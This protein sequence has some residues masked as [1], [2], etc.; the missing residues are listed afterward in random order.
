MEYDQYLSLPFPYLCIDADLNV[1][2]ASANL[3]KCP[4]NVNDFIAVDSIEDFLQFIGAPEMESKVF[5]LNLREE[6]PAPYRIYKKKE[7]CKCHL[8]C[9]PLESL[10]NK[11][12]EQMK[13]MR[14]KLRQSKLRLQELE[15]IKEKYDELDLHRSYLSNVGQLAAGIAHEIRNPLTTIKGFIQLMKPYLIELDK[16]QYA[17]IA[18]DE[19]ERANKLLYQFLNAAKPQ[20]NERKEVVINDLIEDIALLYE[21]EAHLRNIVLETSLQSDIPSIF[22]EEHQLKQVL[23]NMIKN[24]VEAIHSSERNEGKIRLSSER[25]DDDIIISIEDNGCG[26][27][28]DSLNRLF[29][30]FY[31][32]KLSGTGL[33]LAICKQ[34]IS[35]HGG[36]IEISSFLNEGTIFRIR[37]PL[38]PKLQ[39]HA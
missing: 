34:I 31:S 14:H 21:G 4:E 29:T 35:E 36:N 37:L 15:K 17:S 26:L 30:P 2:A 7:N 13:S 1:I 32:T 3:K 20:I 27:S 11:T 6:A 12:F 9:Q 19:I 24:A 39:L 5:L 28:E 33:G 10:S 22:V 25:I 18:L 8:F 23:V 38:Q 16:E